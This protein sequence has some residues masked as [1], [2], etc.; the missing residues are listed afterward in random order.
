M[1]KLLSIIL[2]LVLFC[3]CKL[4]VESRKEAINFF[5]TIGNKEKELEPD[6]IETNAKIKTFSEAGQLD[7]MAL[8]SERMEFL[9]N[10]Q[11]EEIKRLKVPDLKYADKFKN[12]SINY[13]AY[14]KKVYTY[15]IRVAKAETDIAREKEIKDLEEIISKKEDVSRRLQ[16]SQKKFADANEFKLKD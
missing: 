6:I 15:Y 16:D 4:R 12:E 2:I 7:S 13:Y 5:E 9:L 1:R 14:L 11:L 3:S 10:N 8:V